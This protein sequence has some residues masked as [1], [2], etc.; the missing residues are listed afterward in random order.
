MA[1]ETYQQ[2][3]ERHSTP[4][5]PAQPV[6]NLYSLKTVLRNPELNTLF[7]KYISLQ[8][9][10]AHKKI[11]AHLHSENPNLSNDEMDV[12]KQLED[13][14]SKHM[15]AVDTFK[16]QLTPKIITE[17]GRDPRFKELIQRLG[18]E[19]ETKN[20]FTKNVAEWSVKEPSLLNA[21]TQ[22]I[23]EL[24]A[25]EN[26]ELKTLNDEIVKR[27]KEE[28][29]N[30]NAYMRVMA[31]KDDAERQEALKNFM[32]N[33]QGE[34]G[35][36]KKGLDWLRGESSKDILKRLLEPGARKEDIDDHLREL[37]QRKQSLGQ[38]LAASIENNQTVRTSFVRDILGTSLV[39]EPGMKEAAQ[40]IREAAQI[41]NNDLQRFW[42]EKKIEIIKQ[43]GKGAWSQIPKNE[44]EQIRKEFIQDIFEKQ[45]AKIQ[46]PGWFD[47][48]EYLFDMFFTID[49]NSL[50]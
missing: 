35:L 18:G 38:I 37:Q 22:S 20:F 30:V 26:G 16:Q 40:K 41:N 8:N 25:Y 42:R 27:C 12:L 44:Q 28:K 2:E 33:V 43:Q 10:D 48:L 1:L 6:E 4:A 29:I 49:K 14:F 34:R 24:Q 46:K 17:M 9:D 50:Q 23:T 45:K 39:Q 13:G 19:S 47:I 21:I 31:I 3:Q 36:V 15:R 11:F 32:R 7:S 5:Q